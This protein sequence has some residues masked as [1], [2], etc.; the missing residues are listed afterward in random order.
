MNKAEL[1]GRLRA[2]A[3]KAIQQLLGRHEEAE[4]LNLGQLE[5]LVG[6]FEAQ[7]SQQVMQVLVESTPTGD[8]R[9]CPQYGSRQLRHKGDHPKRLVTV[10]GEIEI[11]RGY[12]KCAD[13]SHSFFPLG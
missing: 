5:D 9:Q 7:L 6:E 2:E 8:E 3:E 4:G 11:E 12:V 13:C 10:R 1:E